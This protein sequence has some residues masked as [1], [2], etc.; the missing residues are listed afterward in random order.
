MRALIIICITIA[1]MPLVAIKEINMFGTDGIRRT[2]GVHP[3]TLEAL[4]QLGSAIA[5]WAEQKYGNNPTILLGHDTRISCDFV[6]AALK[7]GLL[8]HGVTVYDAGVTT[9]P[10]AC[11]LTK[12]N[13][14]FDCGIIISASHNPHA[15][16]GIKLIDGNNIKLSLEDERMI[17]GLFYDESS[18]D[19][20]YTQLGKQ[21][22]WHKADQEYIEQVVERFKRN[23]LQG[24]TVVLDCAN[25]ATYKIAPRV[26]KQCGARVI[27]LNKHP[28]GININDECGSQHVEGLQNAVI[29][30]KAD[31]GFAFDGDG[32]RVVAVNRHGEIK[33]GDDIIFL[34]LNHPRYADQAHIVGTVMTNEGFNTYMQQN[35]K[36]L[37]RTPVGDKYVAQKLEEMDLNLGGEQSGHIILRDYLKTG[38]GIMTAL[39]VM[40]ALIESN[41][42]DMQTFEHYPQ[43]LI[44]IPIQVKKDLTQE[45][46]AS[47][48]KK[49]ESQLSKGRIVVR[50]SGTENYARVMVED[51]D[52]STT[53]TIAHDLATELQKAL[54]C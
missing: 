17:T 33:D 42:F 48:I 52:E 35:N 46:L 29:A 8:R 19:I 40:E 53:K 28:N 20:D 45:P 9:T 34:L 13:P 50:Y 44:N 31:I 51:C 7:I 54:T 23:F 2:M 18:P 47:I 12:N 10:A 16:N 11:F 25:G 36:S 38:D 21:E 39:R 4:P 27:S 43:V 3:F 37:V 1:S 41:N 6:K 24:R 5:R 32:D 22:Y 49:Y 15:D 26:F 30:H 14:I